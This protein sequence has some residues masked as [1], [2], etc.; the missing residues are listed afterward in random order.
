MTTL[1]KMQKVWPTLSSDVQRDVLTY[2]KD[3]TTKSYF[4]MAPQY[5]RDSIMEGI[6][7]IKDGKGIEMSVAFAQIRRKLSAR[8]KKSLK[9][10]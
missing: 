9:N 8:R 6:Q 4:E 2:I 10:A 1:Q 5:V 7:E 3:R